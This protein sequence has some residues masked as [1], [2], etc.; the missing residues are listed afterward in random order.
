MLDERAELIGEEGFRKEAWPPLHEGDK[1]KNQ[2]SVE[3]ELFSASVWGV[4]DPIH[5]IQLFII[6]RNK[7]I[8]FVILE[9]LQQFE[10][11][12]LALLVDGYQGLEGLLALF[13]FIHFG[14]HHLLKKHIQFSGTIPGHTVVLD[15]QNQ[16][17]YHHILQRV[18]Y[19]YY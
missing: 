10:R 11:T 3:L 19:L 14:P 12:Q 1:K 9:F 2:N 16:L 8:S 13:D 15:H 7:S 5:L 18:E 6:S 4:V 17:P